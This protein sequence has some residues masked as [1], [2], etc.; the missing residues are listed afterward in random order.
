MVPAPSEAYGPAERAFPIRKKPEHVPA[1][2]RWSALWP[3]SEVTV[4]FFGV[5]APDEGELTSS[6]FV[7]WA[8]TA[9]AGLTVD[10]ARFTDTHG[11]LNHVVAAYFLHPGEYENWSAR[12]DVRSWWAAEERR[13]DPV[14]VYREVMT[15][16]TDRVESIYWP[17][18]P[19]GAMHDERVKI[20]PTP[21]CG[22]YGAMRDRLPS[23]ANDK[24]EMTAV[25]DRHD[26][27]CR[28]QRWRVKVPANVAIIRSSHTWSAMDDEQLADYQAKLA[29]PLERGMAYLE[30]RQ[31][32][33]L[34]LRNHTTT[35][36]D[37]VHLPEM[38]ATG[39]FVDLTHMEA[40]AEGHRTH[41]AIFSAAISRYKH[42]GPRNQLRT[43][44]EVYILPEGN[45]FEYIN[46]HPE[47][48]LMPYYEADKE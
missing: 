5:Q 24:L 34:S 25:A 36:A 9:L 30:T 32:G 22:Y 21:Y 39:V 47:T 44:H 27:D 40:W 43:W 10:H 11:L 48:G 42:Y 45:V 2:Q 15:V 14:G 7:N 46:C 23:S 20:Y 4:G 37:G 38:H 1:V 31:E 8:R 13:T 28:G 17:D 33:C 29:P 41:A 35:T 26:R 3:S 19:G 16:P 6:A 18:F 12:Q